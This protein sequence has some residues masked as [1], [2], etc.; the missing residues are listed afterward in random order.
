MANPAN[1]HSEGNA[2]Y[3]VW[4]P[5]GERFPSVTTILSVIDKPAL[6]FWAAKKVAEYA[7]DNVNNWQSLDQAG[8]V[9][10]LKGAPFRYSEQRMDLGT[11]V[12]EAC[13]AYM[14][15]EPP[16]VWPPDVSPYMVHFMK[17]LTDWK[18]SFES[19]EA[20]VYSRDN[21][22]AGTLDLLLWLGKELAL[23]D[24]KTGK[25]AYPEAGLQLNAYANAD[26]IGLDEGLELEMPKVDKLFVLLLRPRKYELIPV[27]YDDEMFEAFLAARDL[28]RWQTGASS[29]IF[30][31]SLIPQV[32]F[33][34]VEGT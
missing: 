10:L 34:P 9:D 5:T 16:P 14:T 6:K 11:A 26:F 12:H 2:R 17:F 3:Y 18:P 28:W 33:A 13:E 32:K 25:Q 29:T 22:Y 1:A 15:G 8:A 21:G 24:I 31:R 23:I 30:G 20:S 27:Q 19:S 4:P 7:V